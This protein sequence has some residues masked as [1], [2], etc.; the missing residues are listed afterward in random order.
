MAIVTIE[1]LAPGHALVIPRLEVDRWIELEEDLTR[2]L[3]A[4]AR[5]IGEAL[6]HAYSPNRVGLMIQGFDVPHTHIHVWPAESAASFNLGAA[7]R[8]A[9]AEDLTTAGER[10]RSSLRELGHGRYVPAVIDSPDLA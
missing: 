8:H 6:D 7:D 5:I 4:V 2:H 9:S 10:V 1:P 3:F